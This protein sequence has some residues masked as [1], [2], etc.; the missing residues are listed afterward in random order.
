VP[1]ATPTRIT[2]VPP[3]DS[4]N[5][6]NGAFGIIESPVWIGNAIYVSE[7]GTGPNPPPARILQIATDGT[8]TVAIA[9]SGSNGLSVDKNGNLFAAVH[10]D[11]S[12][13]RFDLSTGKGTVIA[14][15]YMGTRFDSPNDLVVRSDGNVYFS[16]PDYQAPTMANM[17][18]TETRVYRVAAGTGV[19]SVV[20]ATLSEPN[21]VT[22]SLD[23]STLYVCSKGGIYTYPVAADGSVG[24]GAVFA[25]S[26]NGD[27]I[28]IDCAGNLYVAAIGTGNVLVLDPSGAQIGQITVTGVQAV[29]MAAFGGTD[30]KTLYIAALGTGSQKGLF[31]V[32]VN[33]PGVSYH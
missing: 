2:A 17:K 26:I 33:V 19:V 16:D 30:R 25:P 8:A 14:S 32:P 1:G 7:I 23:E 10:K 29:T 24:S 4:F 11:G 18:Q 21:G 20:D 31:Q 13:T 15:G 12:I 28:S 27:G 3:S 6:H 22:L 5:S 9:D